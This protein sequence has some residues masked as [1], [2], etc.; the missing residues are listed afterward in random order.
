MRFGAITRV[1]VAVVCGIWFVGFGWSEPHAALIATPLVVVGAAL[2]PDHVRWSAALM[3]SAGFMTLI[4]GMQWGNVELVLP[5]ALALFALGRLDR[6][7]WLGATGV[8]LGALA[9]AMRDGLTV[10]KFAVITTVYATLWIFGVV[11][12]RRAIGAHRARVQ[13]AELA[14]QDPDVVSRRLAAAERSQLADKAIFA[15]RASIVDMRTAAHAAIGDLGPADVRN[16]HSSGVEAVTKL[17]AFLGLLREPAPVRSDEPVE[18][19]PVATRRPRGDL[20]LALAAAVVLGGIVLFAADIDLGIGVVTLYAGTIV[21]VGIRRIAPIGSCLVAIAASCAAAIDPPTVPDMLLPAAAG[22]ALISWTVTSDAIRRA[23]PY[24]IALIAAAVAVAVHYGARGVAFILL[25]FASSALAGYAW[26]ERDRILRAANNESEDLQAQIHNATVAAVQA[27]RIGLARE[28]HDV[29]SHSVG[30]MVMQASVATALHSRAPQD[31]RAALDTVVATAD[32]VL[33]GIDELRAA[34]DSAEYG[35]LW[36]A[37]ADVGDLRAVLERLIADMRVMFD[38]EVTVALGELPDDPRLASTIFRIVQESLANAAR[39]APGAAV[40]VSVAR[41]SDAYMVRISDEG[42]E[43]NGT[44][45]SGFGLAG[46][47]ERVQGCAGWLHT[48][49]DRGRGF[50]LEARLPIAGGRALE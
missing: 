11:V 34:M 26:H 25:V 41:E 31:A 28:L 22:Y 3:V 42:T 16:V 50:T 5:M 23:W 1:V 39:H 6:E 45:G 24:L 27:E 7:W 49:Q 36:Y 37:Y 44:P 18:D 30:A 13:A 47:R 17:G 48:G 20:L 9:S 35:P 4:A 40:D 2:L 29:T 10:G 21:A 15:I 12:R 43:N 32:S 33:K 8:L 14:Q 46:L 19:R 38:M